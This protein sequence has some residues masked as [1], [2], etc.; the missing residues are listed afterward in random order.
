MATQQ[1][2][3]ALA[4][5]RG[6]VGDGHA[7]QGGLG[8]LEAARLRLCCRVCSRRG[9]HSDGEPAALLPA[10]RCRRCRQPP[11]Q[12]GAGRQAAAAG[13]KACPA[14]LG[15]CRRAAG[16]CR[17]RNEA[18]HAEAVR[19]RHQGLCCR[20]RSR[21][22]PS[23][24]RWGAEKRGHV[25]AAACSASWAVGWLGEALQAAIVAHSAAQAA[26]SS[27]GRRSVRHRPPPCGLLRCS[28]PGP[29]VGARAGIGSSGPAR[30]HH[31]GSAP[32]RGCSG[33]R[34]R[35]R[36]RHSGDGRQRCPPRPPRS[37]CPA[38]PTS[39]VMPKGDLVLAKVAEAEEKTTGGILLPGS[40]Q[41]R[42]RRPCERV[43][44]CSRSSACSA[45]CRVAGSVRSIGRWQ[46]NGRRYLS[47]PV[48][49]MVVHI[50][51]RCRSHAEPPRLLRCPHSARRSGPPAAM[52]WSFNVIITIR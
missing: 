5:P 20:Y 37:R 19:L 8:R 52:Y 17:G 23:T 11:L 14:P 41:V 22:L 9:C 46:L 34:R 36:Q 12:G 31:Q 3:A 10:R 4:H 15:R 1:P 40:A 38:A 48:E 30:F 42:Q 50:R 24:V 18:G 6:A 47:M 51:C 44:A 45:Y 26:S 33:G 28:P 49:V 2:S 27:H 43:P 39:Q 13:R 21:A 35:R 32:R 7:K 25:V 29:P 16:R